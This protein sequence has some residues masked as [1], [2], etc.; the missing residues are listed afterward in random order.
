MM[1]VGLLLPS[2]PARPACPRNP[3]PP[4]PPHELGLLL[5]LG[6]PS[7][8]M[9]FPLGVRNSGM[10]GLPMPSRSSFLLALETGERE[11]EFENHSSF[12][13]PPTQV[14]EKR[15]PAAAFSASIYPQS[16]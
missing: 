15:P 4:T 10:A 12:S 6:S 14:G 1:W 8:L 11:A 13:L 16:W 2:A 5:G 3:P 7:T 9:H